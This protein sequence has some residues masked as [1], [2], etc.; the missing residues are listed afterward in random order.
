MSRLIL[1]ARR[2]ARRR[3][4]WRNFREGI[5]RSEGQG[6]R[7]LHAPELGG[8]HTEATVRRTARRNSSSSVAYWQARAGPQSVV[9][10]ALLRSH[11]D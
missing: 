9:S 1:R 6:G 2:I 11:R 5:R 7:E 4:A 8:L 10:A 3:R